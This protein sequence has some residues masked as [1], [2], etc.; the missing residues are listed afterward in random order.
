M[1]FGFILLTSMTVNSGTFTI[2]R[3]MVIIGLGTGSLM[4]IVTII[5]QNSVSYRVLGTATSAIQFFRSIGQTVGVAIFGSVLTTRLALEIP[6]R[7]PSEL[8]SGLTP[9]AN[10]MVRDPK[11]WLNPVLPAQ[12]YQELTQS[13]VHGQTLLVQVTNALRGAFASSLQDVF[14]IAGGLTVVALLATITLREVP[15]RKSNLEGALSAGNDE[16]RAPELALAS[17][18]GGNG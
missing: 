3:N 18:D 2:Y 8:T 11:T 17:N 16:G 14:L 10:A 9:A 6:Q 7:L 1:V 5:V 4:P 12:L 15:L 13:S